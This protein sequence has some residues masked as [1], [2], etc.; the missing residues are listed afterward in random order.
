MQ[1]ILILLSILILITRAYGVV[2]KRDSEHNQKQNQKK[3]KTFF[4]DIMLIVISAIEK[5]RVT[6]SVRVGG[7]I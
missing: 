2:R 5:I 1:K 7:A 4:K 3:K 6:G